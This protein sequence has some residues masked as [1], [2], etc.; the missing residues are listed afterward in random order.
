M[1]KFVTFA[2]MAA[3]AFAAPAVDPRM[4][5]AINSMSTTWTAHVPERFANA[6]ID[7]VTVMLGTIL[8]HEDG[9]W[10]ELPEKDMEAADDIPTAFDVREAWP[11]CAD[12]S[13]HIRDQ[14]ACGSCWAF[15]STEALN[16]RMCI[17][18]GDKT[19]LSP[20]DTVACCGMLQCMSMGCN[21]G[22]PSAAWSWFTKTGVVSG[23][24]E[25]DVG[26]GSTCEP[27]PFAACAHHVD[28]SPEYP[29]CPDDDYSTPKCVKS[30]TEEGYGTAY[31]DDKRMAKDSYSLRTVEKIQ[32]DI[33]TY[34]TATCAFSV[35]EDFV[36]YESGVYQH[37]SGSYLGG[38]AVAIIGWGEQEE[39]DGSSTPY[40]IV[41]NSWNP[42]WGD[43]GT[44][45][46]LRGSNECGI[47]SQV[48]AGT[49]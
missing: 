14:S 42:T 17:A 41:K 29:A 34:G 33:M 20:T 44:F 48:S 22:Q 25:V 46:I 4:V 35:Y 11:D 38:H 43:G 31:A 12:V 24:D 9:Y 45:K 37:E 13:G 19:L 23:G 26:S 28:P 21:G 39:T 27:Y 47:E 18:T 2:A 7:D 6:T 40:W 1:F 10:G 8:P 16:D 3:S 49:V 15:G 30:C 5:E 32:T 36:G